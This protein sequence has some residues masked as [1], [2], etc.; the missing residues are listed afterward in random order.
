MVVSCWVQ[1]VISAGRNLPSF[2]K[3]KG[4]IPLWL[5]SFFV[6]EE[7][8]ISYLP[9][10][11]WLWRMQSRVRAFLSEFPCCTRNEISYIST[12]YPCGQGLSS[13]AILIKSQVFQFSSFIHWCQ[14]ESFLDAMTH[15]RGKVPTRNNWGH[16]W[17]T[18]KSMKG[19]SFI[20]H[21]MCILCKVVRL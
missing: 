8:H 15:V 2:K 5:M 20:F 6:P 4:K 19:N 18:E 16:I 11:C 21:L 14:E 7:T 1:M 12:F 9:F 10:S 13:K 17:V 3:K